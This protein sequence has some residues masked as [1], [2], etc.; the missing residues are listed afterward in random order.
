MSEDDKKVIDFQSKRQAKNAD[1]SGSYP[2]LDR[3]KDGVAVLAAAIKTMR[4]LGLSSADIAK[5]MRHAARVL[6]EEDK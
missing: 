6:D 2:Q 1:T 4:D 3:K 5:T